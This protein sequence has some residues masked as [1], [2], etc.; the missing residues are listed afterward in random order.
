MNLLYVQPAHFNDDSYIGGGERYPVYLARAACVA[1]SRI[2]IKIASFGPQ[3]RHISIAPN[4]DY[5]I[6]K[7]LNSN[8]GFLDNTSVDLRPLIESCDL[9]HIFQPFTKCG[10]AAAVAALAEA[11]PLVITDLGGQ[12]SNIGAA[13]GLLGLSN[14]V[15]CISEFSAR[16]YRQF[17][18]PSH[19]VMSGPFDDDKFALDRFEPRN[20]NLLFVGRILPHKG[21]DKLIAAL[22]N[23]LE[24]VVCGRVY[25]SDYFGHLRTL[26]RGKK[27]SFVTQ[28]TDQELKSLYKTSLAVVLSSVYQD[29]Y[30]NYFPNPELLGLTLLEGVAC[31]C[32]AISNDVGA[33]PEFIGDERC[34]IVYKDEKHLKEVLLNVQ[35][36]AAQI[37]SRDQV[38]YRS[39][40]VV[41]AFGLE[42]VGSRIDA[43]YERVLGQCKNVPNR[44]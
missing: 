11:K 33:M 14:A 27:V 1:N 17:R 12:S 32:F 38:E 7:A 34:G 35:K 26:S 31:G 8:A 44:A 30:G 29:M 20:D 6:C 18:H 37:K 25:H 42:R 3:R 39:N 15:V 19:F 4:I 10:E 9:V 13:S 16:R 2:K 22:P 41:S 23:D 40:W 43:V 24:L 36:N 28:A 21:I 5:V